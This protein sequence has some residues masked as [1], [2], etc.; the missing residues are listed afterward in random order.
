MVLVKTPETPAEWEVYYSIRYNTL[1]K[2]WGQPLGSEHLVDDDRAYHALAFDAEGTPVGV[3]RMHFNHPTETQIRMMGV[4][5]TTRTQGVGSAL[6]AYFEKMAKEQGATTMV[7]DARDYA[8]AFYQKNGYSIVKPT[9][10]LWGVIPHFWM[11][12]Q[13]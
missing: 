11:Q 5:S 10:V 2:E 4:L 8:L 12:K 13:L 9:H 1:R 3:C 7:L 6:L